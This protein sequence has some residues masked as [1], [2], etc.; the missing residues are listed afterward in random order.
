M[1][2]VENNTMKIDGRIECRKLLKKLQKLK[3]ARAS[4]ADAA[5]K[6]CCKGSCTNHVD[7]M[8]GRGGWPNVHVC[9]CR[10]GGGLGSCLRGLFPL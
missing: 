6:R 4:H 3:N 9:L 5:G 8:G 2:I 7:S 10:G 1:E